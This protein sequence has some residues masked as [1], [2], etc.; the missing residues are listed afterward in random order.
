M[1]FWGEII[2]SLKQ[3]VSVYSYL[4]TSLLGGIYMMLMMVLLL[5]L[6]CPH[7]FTFSFFAAMTEMFETG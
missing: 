1:F 3:I 5:L 6:L 4:P 2:F 7:E